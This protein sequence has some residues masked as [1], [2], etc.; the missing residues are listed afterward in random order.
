MKKSVLSIVAATLLSGTAL[1]ADL[2]VKAPR[3]AVPAAPPFFDLAFGGGLHSDYIFRGVTQTNHKPGAYAYFEPR[4]NVNSNFQLYANVTGW[5]ISFPNRAAAEIDI[6]GGARLTID[7]LVLDGGVQYYWYPGGQCFNTVA[8]CNSLGGG[9]FVAATLPN[10]NVIKA[11][12]SFWEVYGKATLNVTDQ[13]ALGAMVAYSPS[14]LNSGANGF[15]VEGNAKYT[16]QE[17]NN[18]KPY[19]AGTLG[20]WSLG[21]SDAFYA[22]AGFPGGIPFKSYA[23]WSAAIGG[24]WKVVS[25]EA[26]Y[27]GSSLNKGDCNAFT[28]DHTASGVFSTAINPGGPASNWCDHRIVGRATFDITASSDLK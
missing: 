21:T 17:I 12:L 22:V 23:N 11:D 18:I 15:Y 6:F 16:F 10:G 14:V 20:Y 2:P 8:L 25:V 26:R 1:A 9:N 13:F 27:Y 24:T 4:I 5:S 28:S 19:V 7:K 3:V